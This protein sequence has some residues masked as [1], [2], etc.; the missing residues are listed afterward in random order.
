MVECQAR[1]LEVRGSNPGSDSNF[2]L[3]FNIYTVMNFIIAMRMATFNIK[4]GF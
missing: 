3:E 1:D 4:F 2:S